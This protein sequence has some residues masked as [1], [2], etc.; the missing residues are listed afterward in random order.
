MDYL[1]GTRIIREL[2][3]EIMLISVRQ[4]KQRQR[5]RASDSLGAR[6]TIREKE[7]KEGATF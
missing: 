5:V 1:V 3:Y 4:I 7:Y 2:Y 6:D